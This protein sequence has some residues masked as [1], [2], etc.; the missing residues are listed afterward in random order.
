MRAVLLR[1]SG[2]AILAGPLRAAVVCIQPADWVTDLRAS[3]YAVF[4][5]PPSVELYPGYVPFRVLDFFS[6]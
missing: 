4:E 6:K 5:V 1:A 3:S 2:V